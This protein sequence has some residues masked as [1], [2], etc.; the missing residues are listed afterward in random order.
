MSLQEY[1][2][3]M[4]R[5]FSLACG[6]KHLD[7]ESQPGHTAKEDEMDY[8]AELKKAHK[9]S[10]VLHIAFMATLILYAL[11]VEILRGGLQD[12]HG[13]LEDVSLSW[14]RYIFYVLGFAQI[15]IIRFLREKLFQG[16]TSG[17]ERILVT[18]IVRISI[19]I[20]ALCE[21]PALL[22]LVLFLLGGNTREFY[23][24]AFISLVLF[25]LYFPR[26]SNWLEWIKTETRQ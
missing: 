13:F 11:V 9:M 3:I 25:I 5:A 15:F 16:M 7:W 20:S 23:I 22:G 4:N 17:N 8:R 12:F 6:D 1:L 24:L 10:A 18:R 14:I 19:F 2:F 26:H 21:V